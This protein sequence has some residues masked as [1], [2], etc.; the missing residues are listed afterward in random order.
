MRIP[1]LI[2][3]VSAGGRVVAILRL[4][5]DGGAASGG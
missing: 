1:M 5:V 3:G 2:I 4:G